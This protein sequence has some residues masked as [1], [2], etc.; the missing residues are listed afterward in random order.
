MVLVHD[1]DDRRDFLIVVG[2]SGGGRIGGGLLHGAGALEKGLGGLFSLGLHLQMPVEFGFGIGDGLGEQVGADVIPPGGLGVAFGPEGVV[3]VFFET[4][5]VD[6]VVGEGDGDGRATDFLIVEIDQG[7][8]GFGGD[9]DGAFDA[10]RENK[11]GHAG[12]E[13]QKENR[14]GGDGTSFHSENCTVIRTREQQAFA[15][16]LEPWIIRRRDD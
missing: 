4:D 6:A 1:K 14:D 8:L 11:T 13:K 12:C 9:G 15:W 10:T 16:M 3:A 7:A 2:L 5:I